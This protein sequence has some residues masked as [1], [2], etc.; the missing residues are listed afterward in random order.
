MKKLSLISACL[1]IS[2]LST[3]CLPHGVDD[4]AESR[5]KL[6]SKRFDSTNPSSAS[7]L[8][9]EQD[10]KHIKS[11]KPFRKFWLR[12]NDPSLSALIEHAMQQNFD[13]RAGLA[14]IEN[15]RGLS[16]QINAARYPTL[17]AA[18]TATY[19]RSLNPAIGSVTVMNANGSL[20]IRYEAD[21][22]ARYRA[23]G[24]AA[25]FEVQASIL[26]WL[27]MRIMLAADIT[28]SWYNYV[29]ARDSV[30]LIEDQIEANT[31]YLG[32]LEARVDKGLAPEVDVN[33]QKQLL[34]ASNKNREAAVLER[35]LALQQLQLLVVTFP[36]NS[37]KTFLTH[38]QQKLPVVPVEE[39]IQI[40][41]A[42][43]QDRPDV[44]AA[45]LR[46]TAADYSVGSRIAEYYPS[47]TFNIVPGYS[48]LRVESDS[49]N[50]E[51]QGFTFN[52]G[53]ELSLPIFDG[54]LRSGQVKQNEAVLSERIEELNQKTLAALIE[55]R[56]A[57]LSEQG[58]RRIVDAAD[59]ELLAAQAVLR[60]AKKR[61]E[62]GVTD[63]VPV[64]L[65][66]QSDQSKSL[67][68]LRAKRQLISARIDLYRALGGD[69]GPKKPQAASLS[70]E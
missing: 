20:P 37:A 22:F 40:S 14:R 66:L 56:S 59:N 33:Q 16:T 12:F 8:E 1:G 70:S 19:G 35:D 25:E 63:F 57:L 18:G 45:R 47:L 51:I 17:S 69:I 65:A 31:E 9:L 58:Y 26:D 28:E 64:L 36:N 29:L 62:L 7:S 34:W 53:A 23:T 6:A 68:V 13:L 48:W 21:L 42:Q 24:N 30:E 43:L 11:L 10:D 38:A 5:I 27:S 15:A 50:R 54:F 2:L 46:V 60:D 49:G 52:A 3:S 67:E 44:K 41:G 39:Q 32:L 61:Y 4:K 55:T